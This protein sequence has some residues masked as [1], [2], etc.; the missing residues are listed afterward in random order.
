MLQDQTNL[1]AAVNDTGLWVLISI[2]A[3]F[4][5][6]LGCTILQYLLAR[7]APSYCKPRRDGHANEWAARKAR[8]NA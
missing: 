2:M 6:A 1:I 8:D 3:P 7:P 5:I 4:A